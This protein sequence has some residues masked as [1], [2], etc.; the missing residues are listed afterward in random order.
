MNLV[1]NEMAISYFDAIVREYPSHSYAP[2]A[3]NTIGLI[4]YNASD[5]D[6]AL[7]TLINVTKKYPNTVEAKEAVNI[8]KN[9]Y[10]EKGKADEYYDFLS[11]TTGVK[12][13]EA[14]MDS[15]YYFAAE[16]L[17]Q[18]GNYNEAKISFEK[19]LER[20]SRGMFALQA[21][22]YLADTY[23]QL[24]DAPNAIKAYKKVLEVPSSSYT[25]N[26][27][28]NI[29]ELYLKSNN[30]EAAHPYLYRLSNVAETDD[31]KNKTN[32]DLMLCSEALGEKNEALKFAKTVVNIQ[33]VS[34]KNL[35]IARHIIAQDFID[36]NQLLKA[37]SVLVEIVKTSP[38]TQ[39][40]KAQY[41][42]IQM[43]FDAKNYDK[44]EKEIFKFG[45]EFS[46]DEYLLAKSFIVLSDIYYKKGDYFQAGHTLKSIIDNYTKEDDVRKE[47]IE[48]L[49][50]IEDEQKATPSQKRIVPEVKFNEENDK[51]FDR[52][53]KNEIDIDEDY[54]D[55][56]DK[57]FLQEN[58]P[59]KD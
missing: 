30:C 27:L 34:L 36:N 39:G 52:L 29:I 1:N 33:N 7:S 8:I 35:T 11:S 23:L 28:L 15:T 18:K 46:F 44:A 49:K 50:K 12:I 5:D 3:L 31:I 9:I 21:N 54:L 59:K 24:N 43:A 41:K 38:N 57:K 16:N 10:L 4:Y 55:E 2:K 45:D 47:A 6:N 37:D 22:Y 26:S 13:E 48:K 32:I 56:E 19:Y 53:F 20:F 14:T 51:E 17:Y 42:I 58:S 40:A 25:R